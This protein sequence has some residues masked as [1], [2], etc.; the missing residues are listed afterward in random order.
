ML[1]DR[2]FNEDF[3]NLHKTVIFVLQVGFTGDFVPD[4]SVKLCLWYFIFWHP[5]SLWLYL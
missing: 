2:K 3:K 1:P 4:F 5:F